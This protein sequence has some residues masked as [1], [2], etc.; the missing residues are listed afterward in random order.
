MSSGRRLFAKDSE[1]HKARLHVAVL[2]V[3]VSCMSVPLTA[4]AQA[5]SSDVVGSVTSADGTPIAHA[6]VQLTSRNLQRQAHSDATGAFSFYSVPQGTYLVVV[7]AAGYARLSGLTIDVRPEIATPL[8]IQLVRSSGSL[9]SL[10]R[11]TT[12]AGE[13]LSTATAPSQDLDA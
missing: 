9:V 10:G 3:L 5:L 13:A 7:T 12:R 1:V 4:S 6:L 2:L 8:T 11:V